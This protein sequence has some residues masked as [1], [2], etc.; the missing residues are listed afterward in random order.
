MEIS[1]WAKT[2]IIIGVILIV[3]GLVMMFLPKLP[4]LQ[5]LGRLPGD[6]IVKKGNITFYFPWV[7][8][9]IVSIILTI[10]FSIL[11]R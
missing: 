5:R 6:I 11:R 8:C 10:I 2:I 3:I 4:F 7:T 1:I 9:I